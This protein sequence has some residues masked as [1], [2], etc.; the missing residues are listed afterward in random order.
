MLI[1]ANEKQ[2]ALNRLKRPRRPP[3]VALQQAR[4]DRSCST[5]LFNQAIRRAAPF[6]EAG[7]VSS[8]PSEI[9]FV[10]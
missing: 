4:N 9:L 8:Q 7:P 5:N 3:K 6:A 10:R 1:R 2:K